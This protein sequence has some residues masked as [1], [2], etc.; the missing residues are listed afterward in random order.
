MPQNLFKGWAGNIQSDQNPIEIDI[1]S[2]MTIGVLFEDSKEWALPIKIERVDQPQTYTDNITIGVSLFSETQP[3]QT[4]DEYGCSLYVFSSDW[5]QY[6]QLIHS[7]QSD[8]YQWVIGVNPHGNIGS[9]VAQTSRL[10]WNPSQFS[11]IG[12]YRMYKGFDQTMELVIPDMR[13]ETSY[14]VTGNNSLMEFTIVW[15]SLFLSTVHLETQSGWNL[16]SL[17]VKPLDPSVNLLFP[18]TLIFEYENGAYVCP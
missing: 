8:Q 1:Q 16:I 6:S 7:Y 14:E 9:P 15:S 17:P 4:P 2:N 10:Y 13:T 12:F 5:K 18:D 11:N 3:Y